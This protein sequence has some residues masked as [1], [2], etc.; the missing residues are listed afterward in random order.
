MA[1]A[2]WFRGISMGEHLIKEVKLTLQENKRG[3]EPRG[4][5]I[6]KYGGEGGFRQ[7][8]RQK[9]GRLNLPACLYSSKH[10]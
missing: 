10:L 6:R 3:E 4:V 8:L 9:G 7:V 1:G 2:K 5:P